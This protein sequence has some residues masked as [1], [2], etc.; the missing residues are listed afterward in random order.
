MKF[1]SLIPVILR[2]SVIKANEFDCQDTTSIRILKTFIMNIL[3]LLTKELQ[4]VIKT[5]NYTVKT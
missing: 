2:L 5:D 1:F 3:K 4:K